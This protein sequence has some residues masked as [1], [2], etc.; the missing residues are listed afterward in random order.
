MSKGIREQI[1]LIKNLNKVLME[2]NGE[3]NY[4]DFQ[5][6]LKQQE[7]IFLNSIKTFSDLNDNILNEFI[8]RYWDTNEDNRDEEQVF[9][10]LKQKM[11]MWQSL[12]NPVKL[13]RIVGAIDLESINLN[14]PGE[15]W[16]NLDYMLGDL[17]LS[18]GDD[19]WDDDMES[20]VIVALAPLSLIDVPQTIIQNLKYP[21][22]WEI[23]LKNKGVGV[24]IV[25]VYPFE[26]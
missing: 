12:P 17:M 6:K 14:K 8:D 16:T 22:E 1:D 26:D 11:E 18:A 13:Y 5:K 24:K 9:G 7:Q 4:T 2:N 19:L 25:E 15:H 10:D 3:Y 21:N 20:Y 23:N